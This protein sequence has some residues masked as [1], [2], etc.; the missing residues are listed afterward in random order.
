MKT[1]HTTNNSLIYSKNSDKF[2]TL[3]FLL[4]IIAI[5]LFQFTVHPQKDKDIQPV[6]YCVKDIGNGLYQASFGYDNPTKK[7]IILDENSSI[8]KFNNGKKV[9]KGLNKF[10]PGANNKV[11][12]KEFGANDYVQWTIISNG[13]THTVFANA[14]SSKCEPN[15][16]FI[17]PVFGNGKS[18]DLVGPELTSICDEVAGTVPS[19]LIFQL[20]G[21]KILV[22]IVPTT[23]NF[24]AVIGILRNELNVLNEDYLLYDNSFVPSKTPEEFLVGL[25]AIDVYIDTSVLCIL[26]NYPDLINFARPV[27]PSMTHVF[28][29]GNTGRAVSQGDASQT[30]D[31]VRES[32]KL[33]DSEGHKLPVDGTGIT[34]GVMSN[35]YDKQPYSLGNLSK[36]TLDVAEGDLPGIGN[37]SYPEPVDVLLDFPYEASDE[38]RA[39]MHIIHDVAPG[40]KLAFH[41]GSLSPRNFEVGFKALVAKGSDIIVDDITFITEPFFGEGK[42]STAINEFTDSGGMHFTSA[43]NFADHGYQGVF[44]SSTYL[45]STNFIETPITTKAHVF[46]INPDGSED[47]FQKISVIPGT[48]M[49]ALQWKEGA[50]S[51]FND[52][53]AT[54]DLDIYIVDDFGRLLVGSNRINIDGD[55]TEVIVFKAT[56]SGEANI[57]I[58]SANGTTNVPFRY[59]AFQSNGLTLLEYN[60]GTPT[61]SGH[62]MTEKS[63]T[64]GAIR[65]NQTTPEVFSSFGGTL[66][67]G[68]S[69]LVDFAAPDGVDTNVG[70]I[71]IKY[72]SNGEPTDE[73]PEYPNFFGTSAAAP[74]AAAAVALLQ[75][76]LPTWY[77][78]VANSEKSSKSVSDIIN[79]FKANVK[80]GSSINEQA[81]AGMI[82]ANKVFNSLAAQT[83]KITSFEFVPESDSEKASISTVHIKIIGEFLPVPT[84]T[85]ESVVY[86]DGEPVPFKVVDGAIIADIPPFSGNPDVQIYTKP[87]EGSIGNGGFS[88]PYKFFQDGKNILTI[89]ANPVNTKFGEEYKSKMTFAVDGIELPEGETSYATVLNTLGFPNVIFT[90]ITDNVAYSDVNNYTITPSFNGDFIDSDGDGVTNVFDQC[91]STLSGAVVDENGCS[92][93][94]KEVTDFT[95]AIT[96]QV[97]FIDGNLAIEKNYLTIK[98]V[99]QVQIYGADISNEF[100]YQVTDNE[101]IPISQA[102]LELM[103]TDITDFYTVINT[104][105]K[106]DFNPNYTSSLIFNDFKALIN[107]WDWA[108]ETNDFKALINTWKALI[109]SWKALINDVDDSTNGSDPYFNMMLEGS[110]WTSTENTF[111]A[112]INSSDNINLDPSHFTSYSAHLNSFK[113]LINDFK[114]LINDF[115]ALINRSEFAGDIYLNDFK[116]LI[117]DFKPLINDFKALI[118]DSSALFTV[119]S[120]DDAPSVEYPDNTISKIYAVNLLTGIYVYDEPHYILPGSLINAIEANFEITYD[121]GRLIITPAE[122]TIK[123]ENK[124]IEYGNVLTSADLTTNFTGLVNNDL[125]WEVF[126]NKIPYY[127]TKIDGDGTELEINELKELGDYAIKIRTP[128]NYS[129]VYDNNQG[130][131]TITKATITAKTNVLNQFYGT[132]INASDLTTDFSAFAHDELINEVFPNTVPYYFIDSNSIRY[133]LGSKIPVGIYSINIDDVNNYTFDY[134]ENH[135]LLTIN[136]AQ[137]TVKTESFNVEY[138]DSVR[139]AIVGK[140]EITGFAEGEGPSEEFDV[141][142][143]GINYLFNEAEIENVTEL[144]TYNINVKAPTANYFIAYDPNHGSLTITEATLTFN[145]TEI[146][147]IYGETPVIIPGFDGFHYNENENSLTEAIYYFKKDGDATEYK[148]G[149]KMDIGIYEIFIHDDPTDNYSIV[150][151]NRSTLT[152]NKATLNVT[153]SPEELIVNQ[154]GTPE[155][156]ASFVDFVYG[157]NKDIVFP[158]GIPYEFV[159]EF[160][161]IFSDTSVPGV[162]TIRVTDPTNYIMA[163]NNIATLFVNPF[164]DEI[165]KVRTYADCVKYNGPYDYTVNF[166]YENDNTEAVYVLLDTENYLSGPAVLSGTTGKLPT[167]FMP[168]SGTFEIDFNGEQLV[169]NLTT[170]EGTHKSSVSSASTSGANVCNAKLDGA[171]LIGPNPFFNQLTITQT[172]V[173]TSWVYIYNMYGIITK[174]VNHEYKFDGTVTE[175]TIPTSDL[176]IGS[177]Y[178]VRIQSENG[179]VRSYNIIKQ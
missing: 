49:I 101:G 64:I 154:Y 84:S 12:T 158:T 51:Q 78:D 41:T 98:P 116:P 103:Y 152:I 99:D 172:I 97:N 56:G 2:S 75:S 16:G 1:T 153:I 136:P 77:P 55:P 174:G 18:T 63:V 109:N 6:I 96:Y 176:I 8:I 113:P 44:N 36:A 88:E 131:L 92:G 142:N 27:Y 148:I 4:T 85:E 130:K 138:G 100:I 28:G 95:P 143:E 163:Y 129:I 23:T 54:N 15:D 87:K 83:S 140:T 126:S 82:D 149:D 168:G 132:K 115:K 160:G 141:F 105:H 114:P 127:F 104:A 139:D 173:E 22:E 11:F 38:G 159:D 150:L 60:D 110:S 71:G 147:I 175:I 121:P 79:L 31:I 32:F 5:F 45:P 170:Y 178:V 177:L 112:L 14:N 43:G 128:Q 66:T 50:A 125:Q 134:G 67:D 145:P 106:L 24:N 118:N 146:T 74:S 117:N 33:I 155:I 166:R 17:V 25:S 9:A 73:T 47:Y 162:F 76:A 57:L 137:L 111:K 42:I 151:N 164:N 161:N 30:S 123:T 69:A 91:P 86:L 62:A 53:G 102:D 35:S 135:G 171:Y 65:Y 165:K 29:D 61:V 48:Y 122:L 37:T 93:S 34:I 68:T 10:N 169:W 72:F 120:T 39:M 156:L 19:D 124:T 89:T 20:E 3:K 179:G 59:I 40:A 81:G 107:D 58:T 46:G 70:S 21:N 119:V 108:S 167:I 133:E 26:K 90:T 80:D 7:E 157:N 13:N 52:L 144:G 94:Q